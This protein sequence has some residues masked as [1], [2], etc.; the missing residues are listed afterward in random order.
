MPCLLCGCY[1]YEDVSARAYLIAIGVDKNDQGDGYLYTLQFAKPIN[2]AGKGN[3]GKTSDS[4]NGNHKTPSVENVVVQAGTIYEAL[5]ILMENFAKIPFLGTLEILVVCEDIAMEGMEKIDD[6]LSSA[7]AVKGNFLPV[8]AKESAKDFLE[9]IKPAFEIN[10]SKYYETFFQKASSSYVSNVNMQIF[11]NENKNLVGV[12]AVPYVYRGSMEEEEDGDSQQGSDRTYS[13]IDIP[14][15]KEIEDIINGSGEKMVK[16]IDLSF[17]AADIGLAV[18]E[19]MKLKAIIPSEEVHWY[20]SINHKQRFKSFVYVADTIRLEEDSEG[21][22]GSE[23]DVRIGEANKNKKSSFYI[24]N[25]SPKSIDVSWIEGN[26]LISLKFDINATAFL[27]LDNEKKKKTEE[28][29]ERAIYR[30]VMKVLIKSSE[31][32]EADIYDFGDIFISRCLNIQDVANQ[33]WKE[34]YKNARFS[35]DMNVNIKNTSRLFEF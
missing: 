27:T 24:S 32:Y 33:N 12:C 10:P 8:V 29:L 5:Q 22:E 34:A 26:P 15:I 28:R 1:D 3:Q 20:R 11:T 35:V 30:D 2:F 18:F 9:N 14:G 19:N 31:E 23:N 17:K 21:G 4:E 6:E 25:C 13:N 16:N 7:F